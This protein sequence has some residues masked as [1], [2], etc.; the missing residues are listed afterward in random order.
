M[1]QICTLPIFRYFFI[2][3]LQ[4]YTHIIILVFGMK[5][6][7]RGKCLTLKDERWLLT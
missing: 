1:H 3:S 7:N 5:N 2:A 4:F 6:K